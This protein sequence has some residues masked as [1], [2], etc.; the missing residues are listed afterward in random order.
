MASRTRP[1][2]AASMPLR[3]FP[4]VI[5]KP[6]S[7]IGVTADR[8]RSTAYITG[9]SESVKYAVS[10]VRTTS[11]MNVG[12]PAAVSWNAASSAPLLAS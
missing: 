11:L 9:C 4:S 5:G 3:L 6:V 10:R 7:A 1:F 8:S 2:R 12:S